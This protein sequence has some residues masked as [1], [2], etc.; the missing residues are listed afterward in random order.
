V[1]KQDPPEAA[2]FF[3]GSRYEEDAY[4]D[5]A[6]TERPP[7]DTPGPTTGS[8]SG[9][10][11]DTRYTQSASGFFGDTSYEQPETREPVVRDTPVS[12][13]P[14]YDDDPPT[15][16]TLHAVS[17]Q[18]DPFAP[19]AFHYELPWYR[20]RSAVIAMAAIA[21]AVIAI[22]VAA[23]LLVAGS[24]DG[25]DTPDKGTTS[26]PAT[27]SSTP[28]T[29]PLEATEPPPPP[30]PPPPPPPPPPAP[31]DTGGGYYPQ[32]PRGNQSRP[33]VTTPET[34][35]PNIVVR[36]SHRPAFPGQPGEH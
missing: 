1:A 7:A 35:G 16:P 27:T 9:F 13:A 36:P 30:L 14:D 25:T 3:T 5:P 21:V 4:V 26:T 33:N 20:K 23:V 22:L 6:A 11:N 15:D 29:T 17:A 28:T 32:Y 31:A 34:R 10:F 19:D 24:W 18:Y 12:Q 2:G 8:A